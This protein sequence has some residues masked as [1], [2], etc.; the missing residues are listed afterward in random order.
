MTRHSLTHSLVGAGS[1]KPPEVLAACVVLAAMTGPALGQAAMY[2]AIDL[3]TLPGA[4]TPLSTAF[5]INNQHEI[6]GWSRDANNSEHAVVW[7]YCPNYGLAEFALHDLTDLA[8]LTDFGR[9]LDINEAGLVVGRQVDSVTLPRPFLWDLATLP[10]LSTLE[11]GTFATDPD[12]EGLAYA[13]NNASPAVIVG[14]AQNDDLCGLTGPQYRAFKYVEGDAASALVD[15]GVAGSDTYSIAHDVSSTSVPI[16]SG[17]SANICNFVTCFADYDAVNWTLA[18]PATLTTLPDGGASYGSEAYGVNDSGHSAGAIRVPDSSCLRHAGFWASSTSTPVDLGTVGM[19]TDDESIAYEMSNAGS[20]G[21]VLV[22][23]TNFSD[24]SAI[25]W[26]R[27]ASGTWTS[28][29]L[30][31][32]ISPLCGWDLRV[33]Y[34]VSDDGWIVGYGEIG[35]EIHGFLLRPVECVGD[36]NRDCQ[37]DGADLGLLIAS[38]SCSAPCSGCLADLNLDGAIDSADLGGLLANWAA[39]CECFSCPSSSS[40]VM[41]GGGDVFASAL[42]EG[43]AVLGFDSVSSFLSW[44]GETTAEQ[45]GATLEWLAIYLM[46]HS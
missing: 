16:V 21:E 25:R 18:S 29:D 41:A 24:N 10:T 40:K 14:I 12:S 43:L 17:Y 15:L 8:S 13:V 6:V 37:V 27:N 35:G 32:A 2:E 30:N 26:H 23:G 4:S 33:A 39:A 19:S 45:R 31:D 5:A 34:D 3:G 20:S 28:L 36:L 44:A 7:L 11:L 1:A 9:A 38:Y 46:S 22:V 42:V